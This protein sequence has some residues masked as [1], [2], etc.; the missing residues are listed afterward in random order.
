VVNLSSFRIGTPANDA[1]NQHLVRNIK[2]KEAVSR[3]ARGSKCIGLCRR[4]R[5]SI[6]K[7]SCLLAIGLIKT[8]LDLS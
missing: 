5:K 1:F 6:K 2:K 8:V 4:T 7:P 3:N